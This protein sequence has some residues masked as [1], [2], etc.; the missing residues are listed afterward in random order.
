MNETEITR[1]I[2]LRLAMEPDVAVWRNNTGAVRTRGTM[3]RYGLCPGSSDT[4]G[5]VRG[6]F[7][8]LETKR[9]VKP[10]PTSAE[11]LAFM[12]LVRSRGGFAA[13]VH[14]VDE[15]LS[16]VARAKAGASE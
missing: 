8:A 10:K 15:A 14:S 6:R 9:P 16:A 1:A 5:I 2:H 11:Q 4:I 13:V 3:F 12:A 7:L